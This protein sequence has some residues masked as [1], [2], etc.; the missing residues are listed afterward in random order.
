M[1]VLHIQLPL[2]REMQ[3]AQNASLDE[4]KTTIGELARIPSSEMSRVLETKTR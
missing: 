4:T 1:Y 3:H 2:M